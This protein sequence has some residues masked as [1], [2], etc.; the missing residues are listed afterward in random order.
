MVKRSRKSTVAGNRSRV[1]KRGG[2]L[3]FYLT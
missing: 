1:W 2:A 3:L